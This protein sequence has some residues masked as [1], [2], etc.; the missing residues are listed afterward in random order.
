MNMRTQAHSM[1]CMLSLITVLALQGACSKKESAPET[2][3]PE[4]QEVE[5]EADVP[6]EKPEQSISITPIPTPQQEAIEAAPNPE[7][8][9]QSGTVQYNSGMI[10]NVNP[11]GPAASV[12]HLVSIPWA[13]IQ[14]ISAKF[15]SSYDQVDGELKRSHKGSGTSD[16]LREGTYVRTYY[17]HG[18]MMQYDTGSDPPMM[19]EGQK[20]RRYSDGKYMHT[21]TERQRGTAVTKR[22][23]NHMQIKYLGGEHLF[24]FI[25]SLKNVKELPRELVDEKP[26]FVLVGELPRYYMTF[27]HY[28][29]ENT[30]ILLKM[31]V[32][33]SEKHST[34]VIEFK[35][36]I[37]NIEFS[38]D[39]FDFKPLDGVET[40]DM[41]I[42]G[43]KL[44]PATPHKAVAKEEEVSGDDQP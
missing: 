14:S 1:L 44:Q 6:Q 11:M 13:D 35:D 20:L 28:I 2:P 31:V 8:K 39:H 30:G 38:E 34:S 36:I 9:K 42:P 43:A 32:E 27:R 41:T 17:E 7:N 12:Q 10:I 21:V 40:Q 19:I 29:D 23:S 4:P 37:V 25:R 22:F 15:T 3:P 16:F 18:I 26:A 33:N 5:T 24:R